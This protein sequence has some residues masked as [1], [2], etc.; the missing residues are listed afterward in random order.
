M[1]EA[2]LTFSNVEGHKQVPE[3]TLT[4]SN[5]LES[6]WFG[7]LSFWEILNMLS[8]KK[9]CLEVCRVFQK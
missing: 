2:T 3:A 9:N 4:F 8:E 1:P 7:G 5:V 6:H